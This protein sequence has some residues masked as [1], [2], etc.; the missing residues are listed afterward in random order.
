MLWMWTLGFGYH[1]DRTACPV[2]PKSG[3]S[4]NARY[5]FTA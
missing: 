5:W 2:R 1:E 4:A 3:H